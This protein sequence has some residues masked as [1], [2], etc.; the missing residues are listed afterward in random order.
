[1]PNKYPLEARQRATRIALDRL[2]DYPSP[3]AATPRACNGRRRPMFWPCSRSTPAASRTE[4]PTA[5]SEALVPGVIAHELRQSHPSTIASR[6]SGRP[7]AVAYAAEVLLG[8]AEE[9]LA[10]SVGE[11]HA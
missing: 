6:K 10:H 8:R 9:Y 4:P 3:W 1:M 5:A 11:D 7:Q 2:P